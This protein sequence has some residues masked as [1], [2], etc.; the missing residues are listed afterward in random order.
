M[1]LALVAGSVVVKLKLRLSGSLVYDDV[2][3]VHNSDV[4]VVCFDSYKRD[5]HWLLTSL[6]Y[7]HS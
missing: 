3:V 6:A 7:F 4:S 1:S 2:N 5:G